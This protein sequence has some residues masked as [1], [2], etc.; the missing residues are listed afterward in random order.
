MFIKFFPNTNKKFNAMK[1]MLI[2][3]LF[4]ISGCAKNNYTQKINHCGGI[5]IPICYVD[6]DMEKSTRQEIIYQD[7]AF[8][9]KMLRTITFVIDQS[10][11]TLLKSMK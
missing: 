10:L 6:V 3:T 7:K 8:K 11:Q 2:I 4:F 5:D 9:S 1:V